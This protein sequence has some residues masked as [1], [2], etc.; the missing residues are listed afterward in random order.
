[1][2]FDPSR[3]V[4]LHCSEACLVA[5]S[6]NSR[7]M[8]FNFGIGG[9]ARAR[10]ALG[11]CMVF[12][13][14]VCLPGTAP[15]G[16]DTAW[17]NAAFVAAAKLLTQTETVTVRRTSVRVSTRASL[18]D[19]R[20]DENRP[21]ARPDRKL[22]NLSGG[23]I[24]WQA[25]SGCVPGQLRGVLHQLVSN[26][27]PVTVTSTC[28]SQG[29]NRA[30]GGAGHSYH[31]SGQAVDFRVRGSSGAAYAYLSQNGSVGGLK[32]YGGGLFHID[33]GPRRSW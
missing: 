6:E 13:G 22:P 17:F 12:T 25:P 4:L 30:A 1:M 21:E 26:F 14:S 33:T 28:R 19:A 24:T 32:H 2:W 10:A 15:A 5:L 11:L 27:G 9:R 7:M 31:L 23:G 16:D 8:M 29:A 20:V 3:E 18:G